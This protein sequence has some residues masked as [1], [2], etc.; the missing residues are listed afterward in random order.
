VP[1]PPFQVNEF[2]GQKRALLPILREQDGA[3]ARGEPLPHVL[4]IG[5]S[6]LGK[7]LA[8]RMIAERART[9]MVKFNSTE[10]AA[11]V[12][13]RLHQMQ[14]CD[15]AFFDECHKLP[16][17]LQEMLYEV[18]DARTVPGKL[19]PKAPSQEPVQVAPITLI[20][21]TDQPGKLL[22]ALSKRIAT[23]V[24]FAP[25]PEGELKEIVARVAKDSDVLL[26]PQSARCLAAACNGLP[27]RAEH[28]VQKLRLY[29]PDSES[30]AVE[31]K[32]VRQ[33]LSANGFDSAGLGKDERK[34]LRFLARNRSG[35]LAALAGYLG[36]D[37][38]YVC[39][40]IE[41]PLRYRGLVTIRAGR[42]LTSRGWEWIRQHP[43]RRTKSKTNRGTTR[44]EE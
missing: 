23:T 34:F 22:N 26:T 9:R 21:A 40:Q 42:V 20:F 32:K 24:R 19:L 13:E 31:L 14:D 27:R 35:S 16:H 30:C 3:M 4:F 41:Q 10:S 5:Q 43:L 33:Y 38:A 7:S 37:E 2:V 12:A 11:E 1:R 6:G 28:H 44:E 25:Y 29:F 17:D 15:V 36:V 18:V 8:A 39:T